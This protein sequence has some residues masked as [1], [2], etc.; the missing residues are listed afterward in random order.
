MIHAAQLGRRVLIVDPYGHIIGPHQVLARFVDK[1]SD[2]D[3]QLTVVVPC[4]G[5]AH[6]HYR[7]LGITDLHIVPGV[8]FLRRG[9]T[10]ARYV[11]AGWRSLVGISSLVR[12]I[13]SNS[14]QLVHSA[15]INCWLGG[16][17]ARL[18]GIPNIYHVH[19]LTLNSS[20]L[21]GFVLRQVIRFTSDSVICVSQAALNALP[22][23]VTQRAK[24]TVL[25]NAVDLQ[26]FCPDSS[27][28]AEVRSELGLTSSTLLIAAFG[29]LDKRK[30][31]DVLIRAAKTVCDAVG[32]A[33]FLIIGPKSIGDLNNVYAQSLL[34]LTGRL[35]LRERI[36]FLGSRSDVPRLLRA[37]DVVVQ[38]SWV[39][40]G[41]IVPL[42]AMAT[43]VPVVV[44]DIG[45]NP[46]EVIHGVT[47]LV[48][49]VGD[50]E[51][52]AE[53]IIGLLQDKPRGE[54]LGRAGRS[55]VMQDFNLDAQTGKLE[56]LYVAL[57]ERQ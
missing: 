13:H 11:Q 26:D 40:A 50:H 7:N 6:D 16:I 10:P 46:E 15:N 44:T 39:E 34:D 20:P 21:V 38:P 2:R 9:M 22:V 19:D 48:V 1:L 54:Q 37:V 27:A 41:P 18:T 8:E 25:H 42:E 52:M 31:Q 30:G 12:L 17:A 3:W 29:T 51:S 24:C 49:P 5:P 4:A 57:L 14:I 56:A 45:A 33:E 53:A 28:R 47:G 32:D 23:P 35:G 36:H 43:G 55:R